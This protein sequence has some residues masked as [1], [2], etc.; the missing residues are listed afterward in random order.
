MR[1]A[2]ATSSEC[3]VCIFLSIVNLTLHVHPRAQE[4]DIFLAVPVGE[5]D[6]HG[7][8]LL[9]LHEVAG[10]VVLRDDRILRAR[11]VR[12]TF[13]FTVIHYPRD[14]IH[15]DTYRHALADIGR[16]R[17]LVI[18]QNPHVVILDKRQ[19]RLPGLDELPLLN[20]LA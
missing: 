5:D 8:T 4:S 19:Q 9:D 12:Q 20:R 10:R 14:R 6:L 17:L 16:L 1:R 18:G 3:S 11:G 15:L 13:H 7:Y 2:V